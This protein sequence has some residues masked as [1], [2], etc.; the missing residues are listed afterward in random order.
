MR[1]SQMQQQEQ[2]R[3]NQEERQKWIGLAQMQQQQQQQLAQGLPVKQGDEEMYDNDARHKEYGQENIANSSEQRQ[4]GLAEAECNAAG[5]AQSEASD[6]GI[7]AGIRAALQDEDEQTNSAD[8][9]QPTTEGAELKHQASASST[10]IQQASHVPVGLLR[11][12]GNKPKNNTKKGCPNVGRTQPINTAQKEASP[13]PAG[14]DEDEETRNPAEDAQ[15]ADYTQNALDE[16]WHYDDIHLERGVRPLEHGG[17]NEAAL[18][19]VTTWLQLNNNTIWNFQRQFKR[20]EYKDTVTSIHHGPL[21]INNIKLIAARYRQ[22]RNYACVCVKRGKTE[23][24]N[25]NP[26]KISRNDIRENN[27]EQL[28]SKDQEFMLTLKEAVFEEEDAG[29]EKV[30]LDTCRNIVVVACVSVMDV[31]RPIRRIT[32]PTSQD[33]SESDLS[34]ASPDVESAMAKEDAK[35]KASRS[36]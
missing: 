14:R 4:S 15:W 8:Q 5:E 11:R 2:A 31:S 19:L 16:N 33:D 12:P 18:V 29:R 26:S 30:E 17:S 9:Q 27:L 21:F 36:K 32:A 28:V 23:V 7:A 13:P 25:W 10:T 24:Y 1:K 6:D 22:L 3:I 34:E 35:N 20:S